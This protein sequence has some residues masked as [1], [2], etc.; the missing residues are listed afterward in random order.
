MMARCRTFV[1]RGAQDTTYCHDI[2]GYWRAKPLISGGNFRL[3]IGRRDALR[4]S[5]YKANA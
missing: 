2:F 3:E 5:W 1:T 4:V